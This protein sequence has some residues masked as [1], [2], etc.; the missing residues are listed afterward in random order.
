MIAMIQSIYT[1]AQ[2]VVKSVALQNEEKSGWQPFKLAV[3]GNNVQNGVFFFSQ[4]S[5]CNSR[6]VA[7]LK[8]VNSNTYSVNVSYR[9]SAE[10]P[11]VNIKL[12]ALETIEGSCSST[13]AN[14]LKLII[15]LPKDKSEEERKK[16]KEYIKLHIVVSKA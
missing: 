14:L 4:K 13:D 12:P 15:D 5:D 11:T 3:D 2:G 16:I 7:F 8:L 10:S 1:K 6:Q 9:I